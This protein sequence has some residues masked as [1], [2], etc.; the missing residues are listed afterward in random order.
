MSRVERAAGRAGLHHRVTSA[1]VSGIKQNIEW[2]AMLG[3]EVAPVRGDLSGAEPQP[4]RSGLA[5]MREFTRAAFADASADRESDHGRRHRCRHSL[6]ETPE[7]VADLIGD[8][9]A[10]VERER[11]MPCTNCGLAPLSREVAGGKLN[12]LGAGAKLARQR[13]G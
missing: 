2:K 1:T 8:A 3:S 11:L 5:R 9:L 4:D 12:A 6:I 10:H 7:A 13:Y